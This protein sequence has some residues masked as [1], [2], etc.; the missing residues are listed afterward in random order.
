MSANGEAS[1]RV[2]GAPPRSAHALDREQRAEDL[3]AQHGRAG[4]QVG[5][6]GGRAEPA[7][8]G[9]RLAAG[10]AI[11]PSRG[12]ALRVAVARAPAPRAR[13]R[14]ARR[15]RSARPGPPRARRRRRPGAR[16]ACRPR[17]SCASTRAP[18]STSARRRRTPSATIAGHR[19]VEVGV[20]VHDHAVL[21]AHLG[22]HALHVAL[23]RRASRPRPR[24]ISSPTALEPV[25]AIVCTPGWRTSAAPA[26]PK[27]GSSA[28]APG[29]HAGLAQRLHERERARRRLLGRLQHHRVAGGQRRGGHARTGSRAGSSTARSPPPRRAARSASCCARPAPGAA[30]ARARARPPRA[31]STRGSR[32]PRTRRRP[33]PAHGFAHS[34]TWSA[35][36][37][38]RRSRSSAAARSEHLG[39]RSAP[40]RAPRGG[41]SAAAATAAR[42]VVLGVAPAAAPPRASGLPGSV[43]SKRLPS[44]RRARRADPA[45]APRSGSRGV[46]L[47]Q[48]RDQR[49]ARGRAPQ[50]ERGLVRERLHGA[51]QQLVE[52][53]AARLLVQERLV[54]GVLEQPP[55]EVGHAGHELAHR[56]VGAHAQ[57]VRGERVLRGRRRGRA[58]PAARG[59]ASSPPSARLQAIACA[60]ERR[61]CD[62]IATRT[63]GRASSSRRV[64]ASKLRSHSALS[65][66]TGGL[67]AVLARLDHL[68]VPVGALHEPHHERRRRGRRPRPVEDPL[69]LRRRVAQVG[70]EHDARGRARRANSS[71]SSSSK[72]RS[73]VV[74]SESTRLHVDVQVRAEVA[75]AL[76]AAAAAAARRPRGRAPARPGACSGVSAET[77]TDRLARGSGPLESRSSSGRSG[78]PSVGLASTSSASAQRAA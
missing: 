69:E 72:T 10:P 75:R 11:R 56:A 2:A 39:A 4:R 50:L 37:S 54:R 27:P 65:S 68:V 23:A 36:S 64:S 45:P 47:A 38:S 76:R 30:R 49:L 6:D 19:L 17:A 16:P 13:S 66:N 22:H 29:G 52:R 9:H 44:P 3:L 25:K 67:P 14:A 51:R 7:L 63:S 21:A 70:L 53:R 1:T 77:F 78:Q 15:C 26:S 43:D 73:S 48:R 12:R 18:P 42:R 32:S 57:A 34:R 33:P 59:R 41:A 71:S 24:T 60:T 62:A 35:A 46:E 58:A 40:A 31:R 74:S 8:A 55:H 5:G 28:S 61:L 20:G